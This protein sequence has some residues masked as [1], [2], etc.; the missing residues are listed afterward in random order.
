MKIIKVSYED[1]VKSV[2]EL[3]ECKDAGWNVA[4]DLRDGEIT[5]RHD[6]SMGID[7]AFLL[8]KWDV[9]SDFDTSDENIDGTFGFNFIADTVDQVTLGEVKAVEL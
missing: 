1:F 5:I 2:R 4:I 3:K 8:R 9:E 7:N 6:S